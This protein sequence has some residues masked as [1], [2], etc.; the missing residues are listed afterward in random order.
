VAE[1]IAESYVQWFLGKVRASR[2]NGEVGNSRIRAS[3]DVSIKSNLTWRDLENHVLAATLDN[4]I[5]IFQP[6]VRRW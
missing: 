6:S 1:L 2:T 3:A 5:S 4:D